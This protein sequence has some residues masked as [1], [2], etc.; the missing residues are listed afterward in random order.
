MNTISETDTITID[1]SSSSRRCGSCQ[2]CCRLLPVL[3]LDKGANTRC[4]HQRTGKGCTV[5]RTRWMPTECHVWSCRWLVDSATAGLHRPDRSHYVIDVMPDMIGIDQHDGTVHDVA[6][7]QVWVDPNFP[8]AHRDPGLRRYLERVAE[9]DRTPAL[10]RG[11]GPDTGLV[12]IAPSLNTSGE[13]QE[14][15][16]QMRPGYTNRFVDKLAGR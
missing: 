13:W 10:V 6:V 4:A 8:H 5:Y 11:T 15:T 12:L 14:I 2:L 1:L 9:T 7:V 3:A 16:S